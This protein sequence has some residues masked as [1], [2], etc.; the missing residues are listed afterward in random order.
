[1]LL[2][3]KRPLPE[4]YL[5]CGTEDYLLETSRDFHGF[6]EEKRVRHTYVEGPGAH[7][8]DF[9]DAYIVKVLDWLPI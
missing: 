3:Q 9:W 2:K 4:I 1:M 7:T 5:C 8:W 6:L